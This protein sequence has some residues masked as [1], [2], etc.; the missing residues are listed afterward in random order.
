MAQKKFDCVKMK[1]DIQKK[2]MNEMKGLT[3]EQQR[4]K[5]S[6]RHRVRSGFWP[7]CKKN[8]EK[9]LTLFA[10]AVTNCDRIRTI[11]V[12]RSY[13]VNSSNS[14]VS[15]MLSKFNGTFF[16]FS[17]FRSFV[18]ARFLRLGLKQG[19]IAS[20]DKRR[21]VVFSPLFP[22]RI[23]RSMQACPP[24]SKSDRFSAWRKPNW[25]ESAWP[26]TASPPA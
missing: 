13:N 14:H 4:K 7:A 20:D 22:Q 2:I 15:S 21:Y 5:S 19:G 9:N 8:N 24:W 18:F 23:T 3:P 1:N 6:K 16:V 17:S 25:R 10:F 12:M 26:W 11:F